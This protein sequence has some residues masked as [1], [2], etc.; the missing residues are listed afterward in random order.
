MKVNFSLAPGDEVWFMYDNKVNVGKISK[1]HYVKNISCL[2]F[3]TIYEETKYDV[4]LNGRTIG[5]LY[6]N[7]LFNSKEDLIKSL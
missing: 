6:E 3:E 1:A 2:N 4:Q 5:P 7:Q